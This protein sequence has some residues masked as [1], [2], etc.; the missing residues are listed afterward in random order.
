MC[1]AVL[2]GA[3]LSQ[4]G[5]T[6][7]ARSLLL[8]SRNW[9]Y[10]AHLPPASAKQCLQLASSSSQQAPAFVRSVQSSSRV[11]CPSFARTA[12]SGQVCC[13]WSSLML[14]PP[15]MTSLIALPAVEACHVG[16]GKKPSLSA[17][18]FAS[19]ERDGGHDFELIPNAICMHACSLLHR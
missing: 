1:G 13:P 2:Y 19:I 16:T 7:R 8:C 9:C 15:P 4:M 5:W 14:S 10:S 11:G 18:P 3:V 6:W 17:A 12:S